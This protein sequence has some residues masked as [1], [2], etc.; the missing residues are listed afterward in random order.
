M[1]NVPIK[2]LLVVGGSEFTRAYHFN[3][4]TSTHFFCILV[5]IHTHHKSRSTPGLFCVNISCINGINI[6]E[7]GHKVINFDGINQPRDEKK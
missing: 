6:M 3:T 2:N 5:G 7:Y 1:I 4:G